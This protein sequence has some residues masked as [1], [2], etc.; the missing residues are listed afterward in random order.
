V[1]SDKLEPSAYF[2]D[3]NAIIRLIIG[4]PADLAGAAERLFERAARREFTLLL[5]PLVLGEAVYVLTSFYK[6]PRARVVE[7]LR[8]VIDLPGVHAT[9]QESLLRTMALFADKPSLHFVDAY[10]IA[11]AE[12]ESCGVASFDS[13][14]RKVGLVPVIAEQP[15]D[16]GPT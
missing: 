16:A 14:I 4:E 8:R 11:S 13:A 5:T 15:D 3:T 2:L 12:V 9:E 10:L 1:T 7:A 6:L